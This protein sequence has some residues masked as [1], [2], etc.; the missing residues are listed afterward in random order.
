MV[1]DTY[2]WVSFRRKKN[3]EALSALTKAASLLPNNPTV[4]YH[5][6]AVYHAEGNTSEG[7]KNL[8]KALSISSDFKEA[9]EA[10]KLL[11]K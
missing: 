1:Q 8:E 7:N 4:L 3:K 5:L 9:K 10:K 6:G 2:G 11:R